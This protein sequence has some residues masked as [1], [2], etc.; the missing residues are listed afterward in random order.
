MSK[1][2]EPDFYKVCFKHNYKLL[3]K[4][5][6][7]SSKQENGYELYQCKKCKKHYKKIIPYNTYWEG[8]F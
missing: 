3:K 1:F 4:I 8:D 2:R 7:R 6:P 5:E